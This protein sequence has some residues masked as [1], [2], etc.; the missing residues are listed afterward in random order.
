MHYT[1]YN[2]PIRREMRHALKFFACEFGA[3]Y[4]LSVDNTLAVAVNF[5]TVTVGNNNYCQLLMNH[6]SNIMNIQEIR[7][8]VPAC[9]PKA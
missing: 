5:L 4:V 9:I 2:F 6:Y 1:L 8:A 3:N 7:N